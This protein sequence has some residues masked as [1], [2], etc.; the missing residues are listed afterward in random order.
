MGATTGSGVLIKEGLGTM[1]FDGLASHAATRVLAGSLALAAGSRTTGAV[2][3]LAEAR[4]TGRG[5]LEGLLTLSKGAWI[6]P[7]TSQNVLETTSP[8]I[9]QT[10]SAIW[11]SGGFYEWKINNALGNNG[12]N[13]DL[14]QINGSLDLVGLSPSDPFVIAVRSL[15]ESNGNAGLATNFDSQ[16]SYRFTIL[17]TTSGIVGFDASDFRLD[18]TGFANANFGDA[19]WQL[20][21][22]N[23][24]LDLVY[25]FAPVPEPGSAIFIAVTALATLARRRRR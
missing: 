12:I 4:L 20:E 5:S 22:W 15:F 14:V 8:G 7:G 9:L 19:Y 18:L 23:N 21:Q 13:W 24:G 6:A 11:M 3:V 16:S 2:E 1:T 17:T 25:N 10:A